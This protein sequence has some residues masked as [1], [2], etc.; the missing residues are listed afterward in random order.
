MAR[1]K[2]RLKIYDLRV[3]P[4][5]LM[6]GTAWLIVRLPLPALV[7]IGRLLGGLVY[8]L[9]RSRRHVTEV[10]LQLCYPDLSSRERNRL[11]RDSFTHTA[12]GALE[13]MMVWLNPGR[14]L[15]SRIEMSGLENLQRAKALGRGVVLLGG[16]FSAMDII[17][18]KLAEADIDVMYRENRNPVMEWLQVKGRSR[19][20]TG[21]NERQDTP[22]TIR[23]LKSGRAKWYAADQDYGRNHSVFA[24]FFGVP[25]AS[26]TGT[27]RLA[28]FN[29][30]PVLLLSNFRDLK[31]LTWSIHFS[32]PIEGFPTGDDV[33]DASRINR[34]IENAINTHP[35]Q[36][37][38]MHRRFKTRPEG[39]ASV[40]QVNG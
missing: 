13:T 20:F 37:L 12:V 8:T 35:S 22:Q 4:T 36:Y 39:V 30:S 6:I 17:S 2:K 3:W 33:E 16:H 10:N 15:S 40:Y 18:S 21:V 19:F 1:V 31:T 34:V 7:W 24:P 32:E 28:R 14:E 9:G 38:W 11:A 5:W 25:A 23:I 29:D 27:S 26:I